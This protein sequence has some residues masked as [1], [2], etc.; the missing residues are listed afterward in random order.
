MRRESE[1]RARN[2]VVVESHT[3]RK[4][5]NG[6]SM[7][8]TILIVEDSKSVR[9]ALRWLFRKSGDTVVTATG[10]SEGME[11]DVPDVALVDYHLP[12][13][14]AVD[15]AKH[16]QDAGAA[17]I[18]MGGTYHDFDP[19]IFEAVG[20]R[21]VLRKPFR[22]DDVFDVIELAVS[23]GSVASGEDVDASESQSTEDTGGDA[24]RLP[25]P[26]PASA[27]ES[28]RSGGTMTLS[29]MPRPAEQAAHEASNDQT[30]AS[31][32]E[33]VAA[34]A[35]A[36]PRTPVSPTAVTNALDVSG[37]PSPR[38]EETGQ[39]DIVEETEEVEESAEI[40]DEATDS[41][42]RTSAPLSARPDAASQASEPASDATDEP[43]VAAGLDMDELREMV[44]GMVRNEIANSVKDLVDD[45]LDT[46]LPGLVKD[47][48]REM[49]R[50]EL[51]EKVV[52]YAKRKIDAFASNDLPRIAA[53]VI[54]RKSE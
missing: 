13:G 26:P 18:V 34:V 40:A 48:I 44:R 14:S 36:P 23:G 10:F 30:E 42:V 17:T 29:G 37:A 41:A 7:A 28:P 39:A 50:E 53:R 4:N 35:D 20:V 45:G 25:P 9:T 24:T 19:A 6:E 16:F 15:L 22:S 43:A 38:A 5:S 8:R 52:G 46:R 31:N 51:N 12:D 2:L 21:N 27:E 1:K 3:R 49:L 32:E 47:A 54:E 33:P 11:H